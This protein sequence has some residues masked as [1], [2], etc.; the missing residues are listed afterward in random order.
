MKK[1]IHLI[2]SV[3]F[4][5]ALWVPL[6][7]TPFR[8]E[9]E[10]KKLRG[11]ERRRPHGTLSL[12]ECDGNIDRWVEQVQL[13]YKHSFAFRSRL[14][15][16]Y[17][18]SHYL[19]RN[20]PTGY[21]G[22]H[23]CM[24]RKSSI[25]NSLVPVSEEQWVDRSESLDRIRQLCDQADVPCLFFVIPSK[26]TTHPELLPRWIR[27]RDSNGTRDR[28]VRL[29][30]GKGLPV[31]DLTP[32]L[33]ANVEKT[34]RV[35]FR[36][37]DIHW[38]VDGS[39]VGY[40]E[41][42]PAI[43]EYIPEARLLSEDQYSMVCDEFSTAFSGTYYLNSIASEAL[44]KIKE[45][46]LPPLRI[47]KGGEEDSSVI[48]KITRSQ[49][50][51]VFCEGLGDQTVVFVRDSFLTMLSPLLNHSFAHTVYLTNSKAGKDPQQVLETYKP[52]L[53]VFALHEGEM[54]NYL[55]RM[56]E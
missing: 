25:K 42:I 37:Y 39:I 40:R 45:I 35:L 55:D 56:A 47:I 36:K 38:G 32:A 14:M 43:K 10:Q 50:A 22:K 24:L 49:K 28:L 53:L 2:L 34:G 6:I 17:N 29:I 4:V 33:L 11:S 46:H 21:V 23:R 51:E 27:Q 41:M 12:K 16:G 18:I 8:Y 44:F 7:G 30:R 19:I 20:Y 54:G 3:L 31:M 15:A 13:W 52:D 5:A 1:N 26:K 9:K 48:C